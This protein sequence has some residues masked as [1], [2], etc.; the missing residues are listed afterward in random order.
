MLAVRQPFADEHDR[1]VRGNLA[2]QPIDQRRLADAV[3]RIGDI[4][5]AVVRDLRPA[6]SRTALRR[7]PPRSPRIQSCNAA[8]GID[9]IGERLAAAMVTALEA[10]AAAL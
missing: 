7:P 6:R 1:F 9:E 8:Q 2:V 3:D 10:S 5:R 4:A